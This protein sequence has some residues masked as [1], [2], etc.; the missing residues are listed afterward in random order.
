MLGCE[1]IWVEKQEY[2][3]RTYQIVIL[4]GGRSTDFGC[5]NGAS[6]FSILAFINCHDERELA[7]GSENVIFNG[8]NIGNEVILILEY[9]EKIS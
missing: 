5:A 1:M 7:S 9:M 2:Y 6:I 3:D 8:M 4:I